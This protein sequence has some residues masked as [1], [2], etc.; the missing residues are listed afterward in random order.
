LRDQ[1]YIDGRWRT[2]AGGATIPVFDPATEEVIHAVAAAGPPEVDEAVAAAGRAF[3]T[4][5]RTSGAE[6]AAFLERIAAGVRARREQL[7]RLSSRNNGK[8]RHEA[9]VDMDDAAAAF[10]YYAALARELDARQDA[11]VALPD[12]AWRA[13]VRFEPAGVAALVVPWNFPLVTTAWKVAPALAA[14]C[15]VVLKPSE[16]T[17]LVELELGGIADE[18]GLPPGVLNI[19]VGTGPAVGAPLVAHPGVAKVSFTGSNAVG[20][21]VMIAAARDVKNISLEL[22]GKSPIL[23]FADSDLDH[24]V[25]CITAGIFT[26]CGQMCSATSRLLV[27]AGI[28]Q[29]LLERLVAAARAIRVG[30]PF[31]AGVGMGPLTTAAQYRKVSEAIRAGVAAGA[32][33]LTGGGRP[34]GLARGWFV[35]PTIFVDAPL[36]SELWR[37]EIFGPVLA[38]RTFASEDEAV[39]LANDSEYGLVAT[40]VTGDGARARRVAAA[41][42]VGQV[43]VNGPQVVFVETGWG[44][45]KRSGIG[46]ELGPW[47]LQAFLEVK[48]V[49]RAG[50]FANGM[51]G[52]GR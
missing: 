49:V 6:R 36:D 13:S 16:I 28:A 43:W 41:L 29:P 24:A 2:P 30:D 45:F 47:G 11:A 17:P 39:A 1:L 5:R 12:P 51:E 7:I 10:A 19:L 8:P 40:I 50:H 33:L 48:H 14:G 26:N 32:R 15:T 37:R 21:Q 27:E 9:A 38:V 31:A 42:E 46:R 3:R 18:A 34:A 22:G 52:D 25:A 20:E 44:G 35:E 23:V 4:W